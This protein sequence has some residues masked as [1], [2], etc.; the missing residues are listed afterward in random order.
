VGEALLDAAMAFGREHACR[1]ID[2]YALPGARETKNFF[3]TAGMKARLLV[4]HAPL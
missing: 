2:S 3:E 1:G 4:V